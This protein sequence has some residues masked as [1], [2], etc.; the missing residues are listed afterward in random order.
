MGAIG[1]PKIV[2]DNRY[3]NMTDEEAIETTEADMVFLTNHGGEP[4][5][6][7]LVILRDGS[8]RRLRLKQ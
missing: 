1:A 4:F 7:A 2:V 5:A 3:S 6:E 8:L